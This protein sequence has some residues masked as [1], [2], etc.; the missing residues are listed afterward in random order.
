MAKV[1]KGFCNQC[2]AC[3]GYNTDKPP[4]PFEM[5]EH[6]DQIKKGIYGDEKP[7][8]LFNYVKSKKEGEEEGTVT[9]KGKK[10]NWC[11]VQGKGLCKGTL[12]KHTTE[13]PFLG[14]DQG[15]GKRPCL[16]YETEMWEEMCKIIPNNK[17]DDEQIREW[18]KRHPNCSYYWEEI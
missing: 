10:I 3:C 6:Y 11:W 1:L 16:L 13:C 9:I 12:K 15:D 4:F 18:Q 5:K 2:G 14:E 8:L 17:F 7:P